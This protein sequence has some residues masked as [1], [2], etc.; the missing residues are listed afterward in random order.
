MSKN[1]VVKQLAHSGARL[2]SMLAD[3]NNVVVAAGHYTGGGN[4]HSNIESSPQAGKSTGQIESRQVSHNVWSDT[5][6][7]NIA[8]FTVVQVGVSTVLFGFNYILFITAMLVLTL[9]LISKQKY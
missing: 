3:H 6:R 8:L 7:F 4:T 5:V 2:R 1:Q 9:I